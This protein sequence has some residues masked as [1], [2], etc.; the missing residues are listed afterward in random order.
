MKKIIGF[1]QDSKFIF[2]QLSLLVFLITGIVNLINNWIYIPI[3]F[4]FLVTH[5]ELIFIISGVLFGFTVLVNIE[6]EKDQILPFFKSI[7]G[8]WKLPPWLIKSLNFIFS[9]IPKGVVFALAQILQPKLQLK[10]LTIL[11]LLAGLGY[12]SWYL[13]ENKPVVVKSSTDIKTTKKAKTYNVTWRHWGSPGNYYKLDNNE[14]IIL[15]P[16]TISLK[17]S[18][19][20]TTS[21]NV[22]KEV[23]SGLLLFP[24]VI[25]K[26]I[27][28]TTDRIEFTPTNYWP[29]NT[30][31]QLKLNASKLLDKKYKVKGFIEKFKSEKPKS[32]ILNIQFY[33]DPRDP[34]KR[35]IIGTLNFDIPINIEPVKK[36]IE[37]FTEVYIPKTKGTKAKWEK[38]GNLDFR[39]VHNKIKDQ[40]FIH[41]TNISLPNSK[42][43]IVLRL[44]PGLKSLKTNFTY[45]TLLEKTYSIPTFRDYFNFSNPRIELVDNKKG[46]PEQVLFIKTNSPLDIKHLKEHLELDVYRKKYNNQNRS[47]QYEFVREIEFEHVE[48]EIELP[49]VRMFKFSVKPNEFVRIGIDEVKTS[50]GEVR[51]YIQEWFVRAPE[52]KKELKIIADGSILARGG[53]RKLS[54]LSRNIEDF[55]VTIDQILPEQLH[56]F[57]QQTSGSYSKPSF[58]NYNFGLK[59]IAKQFKKE[60]SP[61]F[62][63]PHQAVYSVVDL[64]DYLNKRFKGLKAKGNFW[65]TVRSKKGGF[66]DKRLINITDLGIVV[67]KSLSGERDVFVQSLED[68]S[69]VRGAEVH[70]IG[71]NGLALLKDETDSRGHLKL[72]KL[73]F[74]DSINRPIALLV[75]DGNDSS[76]MKIDHYDREVS[77]SGFDIH[78]ESN[79]SAK[80]VLKAFIFEDRGIYRPGEK[81]NLGIIVKDSGWKRDL[82]GLPVELEVR[83]SSGKAIRTVPLSLNKEGY[84]SDTFRLLTSAPTGT[85][86]ANLYSIRRANGRKYK[87]FLGSR[88][89]N[90]QEFLPDRLKIKLKLSER[91][92]S[93][94]VKPK[95]LFAN[96]DLTNLFGLP[97][98]EHRISSTLT[99]NPFFVRFLKYKDYSF[100]DPNFA[101]SNYSE[102]LP[103]VFTDKDGKAKINIDIS[104]FDH[105]TFKLRLKS[106]GFEKEG[107]RSVV[108]ETSTI[109]SPNDYL[110][111]NKSDGDLHFLKKD[112]KRKVSFIAVGPDLKKIAVNELKIKYST[113]E[114]VP[115]LQR[116]VNGTYRY[117]TVKKEKVTSL[118]DFPITAKGI[119]F[120]LN[121]SKPGDY[122]I[123]LINPKEKIVSSITYSVS[124]ERNLARN[125]DK[126]AELKI[127]IPEKDYKAGETI[128]ME[129]KAPYAGSGLITIEREKVFA[130]KWFKAS[131]E[132]TVQRIRIPRD[133]EGGA[134]INVSYLRD[135]DSEKVQMSPYSFGVVPFSLDKDKRKTNIE[136][137]YPNISKPGEDLTI[138]FKTNKKTK[139]VLFGVNEGILQ[140]AKY[141]TPNPLAHFFKKKRLDVRTYQL[142]DLLL[143]E[144]SVLKKSLAE[145]GGYFGE[146]AS[147]NLNPFSRKVKDPVAFWSGVIDAKK[148]WNNYTYSVPSHFNGQ[149]RIMAIAVNQESIGRISQTAY[150]RGDIIISPNV[151]TFAAPGDI[152]TVTSTFTNNMEDSPKDSKI[153]I[154]LKVSNNLEIVGEKTKT[155]E[156]SP[157]GD[158]NTSF[159]VKAKAPLGNADLNFIAT[160]KDKTARYNSTLSVRPITAFNTTNWSHIIEGNKSMVLEY[161]RQTFKEYGK[162]LLTLSY[163]PFGLT[164]GILSYLKN[165]PYGCSEQITSKAFPYV[166][167]GR[168]PDSKVKKSQIVK[169]LN[170]TF[171]ILQSRQS[172]EGRIG[173][174]TAGNDERDFLTIYAFHLMQ[175]AKDE[176]IRVPS[177]LYNK[178][179]KA[180]KNIAEDSEM[181]YEKAYAIYL[182]TRSGMVTTQLLNDWEVLVNRLK[183]HKTH[184]TD[185]SMAF[186]ASS[187]KLLQ[188]E[189]RALSLVADHDLNQI[190]KGSYYRY[191]SNMQ[192]EG[193]VLYLFS[194]HFPEKAKK[195]DIKKIKHLFEALNKGSYNSLSGNYIMLGLDAFSSI[196]SGAEVKNIQ[197]TAFY[198]N[199]QNKTSAK[200]LDLKE[201]DLSEIKLEN[202]LVKLKIEHKN[203][204]KDLFVSSSHAGFDRSEVKFELS[205]GLMIQKSLTDHNGNQ[206]K[207]LKLGEEALVELN[208]KS[209][210]GMNYEDVAIVDLLPAGFD[211]VVDSA[212]KQKG[213]LAVAQKGSNLSTD[214][215]DA[216]EERIILYSNIGSLFKKFVYKV[217][218]VNKGSYK[219]PGAYGEGLYND[220]VKYLGLSEV[221]KIK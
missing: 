33:E 147:S 195:L 209:T 186:V 141:K 7:L 156:I 152:F 169:F 73:Y 25:G 58:S 75:K 217:K 97:A 205:N 27:W 9:L 109:V 84:L 31:Y 172:E 175:E 64:S 135:I 88:E 68:G 74:R 69:P 99:L 1:F 42:K 184:R 144:Y 19:N 191:Y 206:I 170:K 22:G 8:E 90:V 140:L 171:S 207:E 114:F 77:F 103:N 79:S 128:E 151:P 76:Y 4:Q 120:Y 219:I 51:S 34:S 190:S 61:S 71:E 138:K 198:M 168:R 87:D 176:G 123:S 36:H 52:Y 139:I 125:L 2:S 189:Q 12:G 81:V 3:Q 121:T 145:G 67:K 119:E 188:N 211:L 89:F 53:E 149:M 199:K 208:I 158:K 167:M 11:S 55:F 215:I 194:R 94:W 100:T 173:L 80:D 214:F 91:R 95:D 44:K 108:T 32:Q 166:V 26:F 203:S 107:G 63:N 127:K 180:L 129:I 134:Y 181:I 112:T 124:G 56:H 21:E 72:P 35:K 46:I 200:V 142:L 117:E 104:K 17:F 24:N 105:S 187:Y 18:R 102:D 30:N 143:P 28:K 150:V 185:L 136:L 148:G 59:N 41:S 210:D 65:I 15:T 49:K 47:Y 197:V 202:N 193:G 218:A 86:N 20:I 101:N 70:V 5:F 50:A 131:K 179:Q 174:Y 37:L 204:K 110:I 96:V 159:Q 83:D 163:L 23:K 106:E 146:G 162:K 85:Y 62:N 60:I 118:K 216:R 45:K 212:K 98:G 137:S 178:T 132:T 122:K 213:G 130:F 164:D 154:R 92:I 161:E 133:L 6:E 48:S 39:V 183:P 16:N 10:R 153:K 155:L 160:Y 126:M 13:E 43:R 78:G 182:L 111:G 220:D 116:Q 221:V 196:F 38:E 115:V 113:F 201:L 40:V 157:L 177:T 192:R 29:E 57:I 66:S 82:S 93:G 14:N 54:I 165:Y